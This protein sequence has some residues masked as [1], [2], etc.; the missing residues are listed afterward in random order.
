[1]KDHF[2]RS[3][4]KRSLAA[5]AICIA[6]LTG[7]AVTA[8]SAASPSPSPDTSAGL[9]EPVFRVGF[10]YD[11]DG[12][13]PLVNY[14]AS[15]WEIF[16]LN[17]NF[18]TWYDVNNRPAPELATKWQISPDGK[19]WTF[20]IRSDVKWHDGVPLTA[21]DIA[22]TYNLI[23]D[24]QIYFFMS[25]VKDITKVEAPDATTVVITSKRPNPLM[26]GLY[27]PI[28]PEHLWGKIPGNKVET[29][30]DPPT[31]GSGPFA[32]AE[33][34]K[35][36]FVKMTANPDYFA[37]RP[38]ANTVL[39]QIYT[40]EDALVQ[41]YKNGTLD[42]GVFQVP[43]SLRS[44]TDVPGSKTVTA[45]TVGFVML[46]FNSWTSPKSKGNPLLRDARIR[47]A[48]AAAIDKTRIVQTSMG[49]VAQEG[50]SVLSPAMGDWHWEPPADQLVTYDAEKAKAILDA[51]G[52]FDRDGDG[53]REDAR[54]KKLDFKLVA[55]SDY[56][57]EVNAG[58]MI[59]PY[60]ESVGIK[61][62]LEVMDEAAFSDILYGNQGVD[63]YIWAWGGDLDPSYQ[64][65]AFTTDQILNNND[66][67]YSNP[68][69]DRLFEVQSSTIDRAKRVEV[70]HQMQEILYT[71]DPYV[72]LWYETNLQAYR[73]DRW[74]GWQL[75]PVGTPSVVMN[76]MRGTYI[77]VK[78]VA[79]TESTGGGV[80]T[81]T[82]V[83][84]AAGA[85]IVVGIVI[86]LVVRRRPKEVEGA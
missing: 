43:T 9:A 36:S 32:I 56:P 46:A 80:G 35:G 39:F 60:L 78:P 66:S 72:V 30:K 8:A 27:I 10:S 42:I 19:V 5:V 21:K 76:Y 69:Y 33:V 44:I 55:L 53:V 38:T 52:Y 37:G 23:L 3:T 25:Y 15:S 67:C 31:V 57:P 12:M 68:E 83:A 1:M 45:P 54:G 86:W 6:M 77:D 14:S 20:T 73:A 7:V 29:V 22:F 65:S 4:L 62:R 58:K 71:D 41:D 84:V 85:V 50:T 49:G 81:S 51:A 75:A 13:N 47:Q 70:V 82:I 17:Y 63:M 59:V 11:I 24:N 28:L 40:T 16:R 79:A 74:T 34:K 18:L 48:V 26:L 2:S 64:L 61:V